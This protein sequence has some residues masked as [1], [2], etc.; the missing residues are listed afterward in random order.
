VRQPGGTCS[1][2]QFV[3]GTSQHSYGFGTFGT[4]VE[5][6]TQPLRNAGGN[7]VLR[8]P[9]MIG[10]ASASGPFEAV[11]VENAGTATSYTIHSGQSLSVVLGA[12]W[13]VNKQP[14]PRYP[15]AGALSDV[16]RAEFPLASGSTKIDLGTTYYEVCPAPPTMSVTIE[17]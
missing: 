1:A 12:W 15:C 7:C 6:V 10:V 2:S 9:E 14:D 13:P 5:F 8:L 4:T 3:L 16:T 17:S 11:R